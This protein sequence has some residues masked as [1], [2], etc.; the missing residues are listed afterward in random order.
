MTEETYQRACEGYG[1]IPAKF[2]FVGISAGKL[3][4]L[5][6]RIPFT[7]DSSGRLFQRCLGRL[8]LSETDEFALKPV[9]R[10]S[11]VTNL[12]K[13]RILDDSGNNRL[14]TLKEIE[15]WWDAMQSEILGVNP[16][17]TL[18]MSDL[19]WQVFERRL[20]LDT[21]HLVRQVKHPRWYASHGALAKDNSYFE[22]MVKEYRDALGLV[23]YSGLRPLLSD[24]RP[25]KQ[26]K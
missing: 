10:D 1:A 13:G 15:F 16:Q 23:D 7:K 4:A 14:P 12:V 18:A 25:R 11:Y 6:T 2:M 19:V 8:G 22:D 20:S 5:Q 3:G 24:E 9:L 21:L 26:E 17:R